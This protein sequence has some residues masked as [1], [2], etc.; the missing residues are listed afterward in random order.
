M[1]EDTGFEGSYYVADL[2]DLQEEKAL[3]QY[4]A[5]HEDEA[6]QTRLKDWVPLRR[7]RP[8]P[9]ATDASSFFPTLG[10]C[11]LVEMHFED[12]WWQSSVLMV[13]ET[14]R[15][16]PI[17]PATDAPV[18]TTIAGLDKLPWKVISD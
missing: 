13:G 16:P 6:G 15:M 1:Q 2:L 8:I 9:P 17:A 3:V 10:A 14:E 18:G 11:S 12:G 7:I 5:F 4:L